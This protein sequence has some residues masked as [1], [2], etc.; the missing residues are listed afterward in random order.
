MVFKKAGRSWSAYSF[1]TL[2]TEISLYV[3]LD[4]LSFEAVTRLI[5]KARNDITESEVRRV[6]YSVGYKRPR[7][8]KLRWVDVP[9]AETPLEASRQA[10]ASDA[11]RNLLVDGYVEY[12]TSPLFR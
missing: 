12:G 10:T 8:G 6:G 2:M 11:G 9:G 5:E 4:Q 3:E 7:S 1:Q